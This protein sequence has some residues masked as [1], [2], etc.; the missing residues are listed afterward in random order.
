M[1]MVREKR[2]TFDKVKNFDEAVFE[3]DIKEVIKETYHL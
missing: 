1:K 2:V 3:N